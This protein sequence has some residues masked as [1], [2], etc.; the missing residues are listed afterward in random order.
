MNLFTSQKET[1]R[2]KTNLWLLK[3]K[4]GKDKLGVRDQQ[5][6]T[7]IYKVN[8]KVLLY[9]TENYIQYFVV[10]VMEKNLKKNRQIYIYISV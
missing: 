9:S 4:G 1:H 7:T 2:Q 8:N 3:G 6:H 5:I 10:A